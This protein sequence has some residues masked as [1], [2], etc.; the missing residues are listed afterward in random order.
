M[1]ALADVGAALERA[2]RAPLTE[3]EAARE[4]V[5]GVRLLLAELGMPSTLGAIGLKEEM[6]SS[7]V[8]GALDDVVLQ[9]NP[10]EPAQ[11]ELMAL[12]LSLL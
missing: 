10:V 2:E 3:E 6:V 1:A 9:N 12:V 11:E 7:L 5:E 8:H 4:A